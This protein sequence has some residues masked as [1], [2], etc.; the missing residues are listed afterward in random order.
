MFKKFKISIRVSIISLFIFLLGLIGFT[1]IY[2]NYKT[3]DTI[4]TSS[5]KNIIEKTSLMVNDRIG[6]YLRPLRR[7]L[8]V[9]IN[10]I[11]HG[12]VNPANQEQLDKF[13]IER[14]RY[15]PD[16]YMVYYGTNK[17]DFFGVDHETPGRI[18]L[19]HIIRSSKNQKNLRYELDSKG[20]K[21]L[22]TIEIGQTYDPRTRPWFQ[23]AVEAKKPVWTGIFNFYTFGQGGH[24]IPGI[25]A[26]APIYNK[27]QQLMGVFA[28]GF[29]IDGIQ[30]FVKDLKVTKNAM[31]YITNGKQQ[32]IAY[33]NLFEGKD[34]RGEI[35]TAADLKK[36]RLPLAN[37]I[38][39]GH[40]Q[41]SSSYTFQGNLYFMSYQPI[42]SIVTE[43]PWHIV[44]IVPAK[45][46][47]GPL[48]T[49]SLQTVFMTLLILLLGALLV[50]YISK[51]ISTPIIYL[52]KQ[53]QKITKLDLTPSPLLKT[54]IKEVH[55][56]DLS[57]YNMRISLSSFQRYLP[58]SLVN[59]LINSGQIAQ[60]GGHNQMITVLFSDIKNFTNLCEGAN[61]EALMAYLSDYFQSMTESVL[62]HQG[63]LDKYIGDAVMA[64]WN[65][66][67]TDSQ[68]SIHACETAVD[69]IRRVEIINNK[70]LSPTLEKLH[71][72]IG[73]NSGD[74]IVGNVG[75]Q[76]RLNFTA[77]GDTVNLASRLETTNKIYH[78]E[79]IVSASTYEQVKDRFDF[80][81]LDIITVRGKKL[82]TTIYELLTNPDKKKLEQHKSEF[83]KAFK[84]YQ[85]KKWQESLI[86]FKKLTPAFE[87]DTLAG[88]YI[89]RCEVLIQSPPVVWEGIW[90][91]HG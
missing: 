35:L 84:L 43:S 44:I 77:L 38:K 62:S 41:G 49:L 18:G 31:I 89:E 74:A 55:Q 60:V 8:I 25:T 33:R 78:S 6:L 71:I 28:L 46:V 53:A 17:G 27:Q 67:A 7:D 5:A 26:A 48:W 70:T 42:N 21:I 16:I 59:K 40:P 86:L 52:S 66:P 85:E 90:Q 13:L 22:D 82:K 69:M 61:A 51:K 45:D 88:I 83:A 36:Y 32:I 15:N 11:K 10:T 4:L 14:I 56:L 37:V 1:I 39:P 29:S 34:V 72:R 73:I 12:I 47:L 87:G 9:I 76:D 79:I 91:N 81:F 20:N 50:R 75:S 63:T 30:N 23:K 65:A 80:R 2:I 24:F 58:S 68:H 64:F 54:V 3:M 19:N 57:L